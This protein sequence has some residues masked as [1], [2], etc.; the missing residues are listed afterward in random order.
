MIVANGFINVLKNLHP[1][2][3]VLS[4]VL[5]ILGVMNTTIAF[6]NIKRISDKHF[7]INDVFELYDEIAESLV[8]TSFENKQIVII[9]DLDRIN[10]KKLITEFLKELYRF[11]NSKCFK[12]FR[13]TTNKEQNNESVMGGRTYA[14]ASI[15]RYMG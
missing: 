4:W 8:R 12:G 1:A 5:L 9:E 14:Q 7:E 13:R 2:F 3:L 11:Q 15:F 10:D 6:S